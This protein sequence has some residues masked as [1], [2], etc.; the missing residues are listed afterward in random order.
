[1]HKIYTFFNRP[2][3]ISRVQGDIED[4]IANKESYN[5]MD[6]FQKSW[7]GAEFENEEWVKKYAGGHQY[8]S[9]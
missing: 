5:K 6:Y 7:S 4:R 9:K 8:N 2:K 1:L 3:F